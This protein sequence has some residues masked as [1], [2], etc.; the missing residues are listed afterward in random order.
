MKAIRDGAEIYE[1]V[2][3]GRVSC[4]DG[5]GWAD[6]VHMIISSDKHTVTVSSCPCVY[7]SSS[8]PVN[9]DALW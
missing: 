1:Y 9:D 8:T 4:H 3:E 7:I 2:M 6:K 5:G